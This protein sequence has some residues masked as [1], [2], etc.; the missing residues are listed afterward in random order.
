[1][2]QESVTKIVLVTGPVYRNTWPKAPAF[3]FDFEHGAGERCVCTK[4]M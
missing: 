1:M 4:Q 3:N 2:K